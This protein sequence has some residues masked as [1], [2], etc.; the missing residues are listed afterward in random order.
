MRKCFA[1]FFITAAAAFVRADPRDDIQKAD[2]A[3]A[4]GDFEAARAA[5]GALADQGLGGADVLYNLGNAHYR[6]G[7]RGP[8][9]LAYERAIR[10]SP[11]HE[12]A[13]YNRDL[14]RR[15]IG[16]TA[17]PRDFLATG[18]DLLW[19]AVA[20]V[21]ALFFGLMIAGF[22]RTG[23]F[24]WWGRWVTGVL[25]ALTWV[26]AL[27][28]EQQWRQPQGVVVSDRAEIRA[29]PGDQER[30]AFLLP[31]GQRVVLLDRF[32]NWREIG[33][34]EKS[35]KGWIPLKYVE[36]IVFDSV[37]SNKITLQLGS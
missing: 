13:R 9:R 12:D 2:A 4:A 29:G 14:I 21:N 37:D 20:F 5:Y 34:P 30:V 35:L 3:Y 18:A 17:S 25:A 1:L 7:R 6:L 15:Q 8:A 31:E 28:A 22:Y 19:G 32:E 11:R 33:I 24:V 26:A 10:L 16:E 27:A 36:P 23:E